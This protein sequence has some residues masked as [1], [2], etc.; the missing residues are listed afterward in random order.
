M[1]RAPVRACDWM[2]AHGVRGRGVNSFAFGGYQLW[3][4]WPDFTRLP[5]VDIHPEDATPELRALYQRALTTRPG[6]REL[7]GRLRPDYA[8]FTRRYADRPTVL[9]V[10]DEDD[11]WALVFADDVA[12]LYVRRG[13]ALDSLA[14]RWGY[15]TLGGARTTIPARLGRAADDPEYRQRMR[16]ELARQAAESPVNFY[17]RSMLRA[18]DSMAP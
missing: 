13:G 1:S 5:L 18:L 16:A 7:D 15:A 6:W 14:E 12:A 17:G 8:L 2:E 10:I 9:D 3:R 4:F 11:R